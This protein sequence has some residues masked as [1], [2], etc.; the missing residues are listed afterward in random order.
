M[1]T[2]ERLLKKKVGKTIHPKPL[3]VLAI[4]IFQK[5]KIKELQLIEKS[6]IPCG[7]VPKLYFFCSK[8]TKQQPTKQNKKTKP[9]KPHEK[10]SPQKL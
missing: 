10:V 6:P 8:K 1:I 2:T 9:K 4:S 3:L 7:V 5:G